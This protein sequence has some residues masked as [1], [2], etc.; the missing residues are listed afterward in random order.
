M[1]SRREPQTGHVSPVRGMF[2]F[3]VAV[4]VFSKLPHDRHTDA[5]R[6]ADCNTL[7]CLYVPDA[8]DDCEP[9]LVL[10]DAPVSEE[11]ASD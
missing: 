1:T 5:M 11:D 6:R 4:Y 8:M 9:P 10:Y 2:V 3:Y 7:D